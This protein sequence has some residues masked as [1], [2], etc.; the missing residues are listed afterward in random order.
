[1]RIAYIHIY[2]SYLQASSQ[3]KRYAIF[4][5]IAKVSEIILIFSFAYFLTSNQYMSKIYAQMIV[6]IILIVYILMI[7]SKLNRGKF[8]FIYLKEALIFSLPLILHVLSNS[9]L[10]QADRL[11]INKMMGT[12]SA[13]IYSFAHNVGMCVIVVIM[14][15]NSSWQPKLYE[16]INNRNYCSIKITT[17]TGTILIFLICVLSILFSKEM[18]IFLASDKYYDS[19]S[20]L[21]LTIIGNSLIH[22]YLIYVNFI[23]YKKKTIIISCATLGA[24][25]INVILNYYLIP[26]FGIAGSA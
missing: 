14:A 22:V 2:T 17:Y 4:N 15:W 19:I 5:I 6:N 1:M 20:I 3:S 12:Y 9:L 25:V 24:L 26:K 8:D 13:G 7:S 10:S 18:V 21:P 23:F 16:L 11:I